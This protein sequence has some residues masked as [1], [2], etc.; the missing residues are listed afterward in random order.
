MADTSAYR[1][2]WLDQRQIRWEEAFRFFAQFS[3]MEYA[4]KEAKFLQQ[5]EG[6][7]ED[8][9]PSNVWVDAKADWKGF[10]NVFENYVLQQS[11]MT[12][13]D[14]KTF[15]D[16]RSTINGR[17]PK[18]FMRRKYTKETCW[19]GSGHEERDNLW[20]TVRCMLTVRNNLFHGN[21]YPIGDPRDRMLLENCSLLIGL[22]STYCHKVEIKDGADEPKKMRRVHDIYRM[23]IN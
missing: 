7:R 8:D 17:P 2:N 9:P 14:L 10:S 23:V 4:L 18:S 21:K 13:N 22:L 15:T 11:L 20:Y 19:K 3:A 1:L 16:A 6:T 12:G 5:P